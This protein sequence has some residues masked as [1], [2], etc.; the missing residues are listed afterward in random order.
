M[1]DSRCVF[2]CVLK[3]RLFFSFTFFFLMNISLLGPHF[4][5]SAINQRIWSLTFIS[6]VEPR[7]GM[8]RAIGPQL[9][10]G[11]PAMEFQRSASTP[12]S[13]FR[14]SPQRR[15]C[16]RAAGP[17]NRRREIARRYESDQCGARFR[18]VS[19]GESC[20]QFFGESGRE[21]QLL[22]GVGHFARVPPYRA[23]YHR[24]RRFVYA[25]SCK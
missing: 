14:N 17:T 13:S 4:C 1:S 19:I 24:A 22:S 8:R 2:A 9:K 7:D 10:F 6:F 18:R 5:T 25:A 3:G 12:F 23:D 16:C 21:W 20:F 11:R 15:S